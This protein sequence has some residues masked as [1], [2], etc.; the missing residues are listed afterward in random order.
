MMMRTSVFTIFLFTILWTQGQTTDTAK[1]NTIIDAKISDKDPSLFVGVV[2]NGEIVYERYKGIASLQHGV[3]VT[4]D[5]RSN[6]ASV[7]K[8]FTALCIL[9]LSLDKKISLEDD[10]RKYLSLIHI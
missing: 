10:I 1:L 8:Q 3:K 9:Q 4:E 5:S 2:K 6:V 7:A